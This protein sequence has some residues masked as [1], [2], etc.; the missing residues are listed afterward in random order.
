M[1][2]NSNDQDAKFTSKDWFALFNKNGLSNIT[3][4][5][6]LDF[7]FK[8][9]SNNFL[10]LLQPKKA[11]QPTEAM[12]EELLGAITANFSLKPNIQF[13]LVEPDIAPR[14][15]IAK[16]AANETNSIKEALTENRS[17]QYLMKNFDAKISVNSE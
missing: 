10:T 15:M 13:E 16:M 5:V 1:Q 3:K 11:M 9:F 7:G 12:I 2:S 14:D 8:E 17:V 6:F 4:E